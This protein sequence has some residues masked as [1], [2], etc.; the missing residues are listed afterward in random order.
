MKCFYHNA[1]LDGICSAAIV[2]LAH[3]AA[4]LIGINHG[5]P[6][7]WETIELGEVVYMVDFSLQPFEEMT[8]LVQACDLRWIDHHK[9]AI[10][11]MKEHNREIDFARGLQR[12]GIGACWLVWE[13]FHG[14]KRLPRAVEL[15][16][17]Y[18]VW[19]HEDPDTLP[20]QYGIRTLEMAADPRHEAWGI[21]LG[22]AGFND[23][24][25]VDEILVDGAA[26]LR[27]IDNDNA[28]KARALC[29]DH[30]LEDRD[31]RLLRCLCANFGPANSQ[32]FD[33]KWDPA[34]YDA[35]LLFS[36]RPRSRQWTISLYTTRDDI[37]VS[38]WAKQMG[39]GGHKGAAGFQVDYLS[40]VGL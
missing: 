1:D 23:Q 34:K 15:L 7:P 32:F 40:E 20:F 3:P 26:I 14:T 17:R 25:L 28:L 36:F 31:G 2:R 5:D 21:L 30:E 13:F 35:M 10:N 12:D 19:D 18:D 38:D 24:Q 6:F 33:S 27:Y 16:A 39:G 22:D 9:S 8:R 11:D 4:E 29:F 37:D